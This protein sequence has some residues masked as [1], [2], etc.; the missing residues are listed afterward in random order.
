MPENEG[1]TPAASSWLSGAYLPPDHVDTGPIPTITDDMT[2]DD[3]A[4]LS[5]ASEG[6][7]S[8][9]AV[10]VRQSANGTPAAPEAAPEAG[11]GGP[12][13]VESADGDPAAVTTV[14]ALGAETGTSGS[15][16][17]I[18]TD[19]GTDVA[20]ATEVVSHDA[21]DV[22]SGGG[23]DPV[24]EVP[25]ESDTAD[26]GDAADG[27]DAGDAVPEDVSDEGLAD[28]DVSDQ[29]VPADDVSAERVPDEDVSA[30]GASEE[31]VSDEDD[32]GAVTTMFTVVTE[33]TR[34]DADTTSFAVVSPD[35]G[36]LEAAAAGG[37]TE[38]GT[39][40]ARRQR[41]RA[42][43]LAT[44]GAVAVVVLGVAAAA[45]FG[46]ERNRG[47]VS[48]PVPSAPVPAV[49]SASPTPAALPFP[50][51]PGGKSLAIGRI[52]DR[53]AH[54]SYSRLGGKWSLGQDR[55]K[56]ATALGVSRKGPQ[57]RGIMEAGR[58]EYLS[59][60]LPASLG[61]SATPEAAQAVAR[62]VI[63]TGQ[64]KPPTLRTYAAERL[65]GGLKGWWVGFQA[66]TGST[67]GE[68]VAVAV[69]DTGAARPGVFYVAVPKGDKT[70]RPDIRALV[71]S[72]RVVR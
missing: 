66:L 12:G 59:A 34:D 19:A 65:S 18:E 35:T 56:L 42:V 6:A 10:P 24:E 15:A 40:P 68:I 57:L 8:G 70:V 11:S 16:E 51:Y 1:P 2:A 58:A 53:K 46:G 48:A 50:R 38:T 3:V 52:I 36:D 44:A 14:F 62:K 22:D 60:P 43:L 23:G 45:A 26:D 21:M 31:D 49:P 54:L 30:D 47:P 71:K 69:V 61:S 64:A 55:R 17:P 29:D 32:A 39:P 4:R 13:Q 5:S 63:G 41:S 27:G 67:D 7:G 9:D 25:A 20:A 72:L 33:E 37:V 28:E